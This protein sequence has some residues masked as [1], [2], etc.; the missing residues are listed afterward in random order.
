MNLWGM[1]IAQRHRGPR[2]FD[3][4]LAIGAIFVFPTAKPK[5]CQKQTEATDRILPELVSDVDRCEGKALCCGRDHK[6]DAPHE[7]GQPK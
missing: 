3:L 4:L 1:L 2:W 7:A 6:K 5:Q